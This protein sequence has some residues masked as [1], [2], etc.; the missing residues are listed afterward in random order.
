MEIGRGTGTAAC[1]RMNGLSSVKS[2]VFNNKDE[3][4]AS[5]FYKACFTDMIS[6]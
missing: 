3:T 5:L 4:S 2:A 6:V 1:D